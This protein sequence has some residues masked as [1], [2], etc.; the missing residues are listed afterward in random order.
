MKT[1]SWF[2]YF[3]LPRAIEW[4]VLKG[5]DDVTE[6]RHVRPWHWQLVEVLKSCGW[7]VGVFVQKVSPPFLGLSLQIERHSYH[8]KSRVGRHVICVDVTWL[9][10]VYIGFFT[11][12]CHG[13]D[14]NIE[15]KI[16]NML[17]SPYMVCY[18]CSMICDLRVRW[19]SSISNFD[20]KNE[21]PVKY[22]WWSRKVAKCFSLNSHFDRRDDDVFI[23]FNFCRY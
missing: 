3:L 14:D 4:H 12:L 17:T 8:V 2:T 7:V 6:W 9:D 11:T 22:F 20:L 1:C 16:L 10:Y 18:L 5:C 13:D 15:L 19:K 21:F 23:F